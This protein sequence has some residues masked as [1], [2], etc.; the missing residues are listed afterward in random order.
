LERLEKEKKEDP[1][2][3]LRAKHIEEAENKA[4]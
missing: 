2:E 1:T 3:A 4:Y